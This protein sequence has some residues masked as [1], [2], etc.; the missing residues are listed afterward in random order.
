M[1]RSGGVELQFASGAPSPEGSGIQY[2]VSFVPGASG[3]ADLAWAIADPDA[4][5][6]TLFVPWIVPAGTRGINRQTVRA[7]EVHQLFGS[8]RE[9]SLVFPALPF[10]GVGATL[11]EA[12]ED[13]VAAIEETL[14]ELEADLAS[15]IEISPHLERALSVARH[16]FGVGTP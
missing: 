7:F 11:S 10:H 8:A 16:V 5:A 1:S 6:N 4:C 2:P 14:D 13:I 12:Q 9:V 15:G 3:N